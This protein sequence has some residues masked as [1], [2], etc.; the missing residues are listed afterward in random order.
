MSRCLGALRGRATALS[1]TGGGGVVVRGGHKP[2]LP[3]DEP[4]RRLRARS[5]RRGLVKSR[6]MTDAVDMRRVTLILISATLVGCGARS[7]L[8]DLESANALPDASD[9]ASMLAPTPGAIRS[10]Q[11]SHGESRHRGKDRHC[12][13]SGLDGARRATCASSSR[14]AVQPFRHHFR[15]RRSEA[16]STAKPSYFV[17]TLDARVLMTNLVLVKDASVERRRSWRS[18]RRDIQ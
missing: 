17:R 3:F 14:T 4:R 6:T 16:S 10:C 13:S 9:D 1:A 2:W 11:T 5:R 8:A 7:G 18:R 12:D 15:S